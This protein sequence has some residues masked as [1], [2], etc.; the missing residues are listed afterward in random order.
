MRSLIKVFLIIYIPIAVMLGITWNITNKLTIQSAEKELQSEM[1]SKAEIL[2]GYDLNTSF[3]QH[4][5]DKFVTVS[6]NSKL[7]ITVI[8]KDGFVV[9]D[10]YYEQAQIAQM[11][12]HS[13][14]PEVREA[15]E[16]G[17]GIVVRRST[18]TEQGMYYYA[19]KYNNNLVVRIS[20]PMSYIESLQSDMLKQNL[21]VYF[22]LIFMIGVVTIYLARRINSPI[23]HLSIIA[24]KIE[25]GDTQIYFPSFRDKT[26]TKLVSVIYR[27]YSSMNQK[28]K[29]LEQEKIKLNHI[30]SILDEGIVLLDNKNNVKHY[31]D[32]AIENLGVQLQHGKNVLTQTN[33]IAALSFFSEVVSHNEDCRLQKEHKGKIYEIYVRVF[34]EEKLVV[35]FDITER[36]EYE[37]FK[38]ELIG[39]ITHELKTPLA[40][41]MGYSE[42]IMNDPEMDTEFHDKFIKIIYN[43]SNRLNI[44]INDILKLHKLEML[45]DSITVEEPTILADLRDEVANYYT[46][47]Q[48]QVQVDTGNDEIFINREHIMS[49][50]TNLIDNAMKYSTGDHIHLVVVKEDDYVVVKVE[51]HGPVI[52]VKEQE[53]IF[54]RFY[55][56]DKA[57]NQKDTGTGLGLSI[58]KH[59]ATL[60]RGNAKVI[61]NQKGGNTFIIKLKEKPPIEE[62]S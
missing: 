33:N 50:I 12:N 51:D 25:A 62:E 52:P 8:R 9:D 32:T 20:Y 18:T 24:D 60:Y 47:R 16:T 15:F 13:N 3:D 53:R 61:N 56:M 17:S 6:K 34:E 10:S 1:V 41:I 2:K 36:A 40:M 46:D 45:Q 5:H 22:V 35:F 58:V 59:I 42:T 30:F 28:T 31:N 23:K 54:E 49:I 38:A 43:S 44:L 4:I 21:T 11:E 48:K 29:Q 19:A 14:R 39:N 26:I 57:K 37:N 7:R 27:I 55:T